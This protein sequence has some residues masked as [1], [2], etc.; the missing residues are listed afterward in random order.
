MFVALKAQCLFIVV[1]SC[2]VCVHSELIKGL[3]GLCWSHPSKCGKSRYLCVLLQAAG[4][5]GWPP[6]CQQRTWSAWAVWEVR[7]EKNHQGGCHAGCAPDFRMDHQTG[8]RGSVWPSVYTQLHSS[9]CVCTYTLSPDHGERAAR[10]L[11]LFYDSRY[12]TPTRLV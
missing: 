12:L 5:R 2:L 11:P 10:G 9:Q 8:A 4:S 7:G 6:R 1:S 3:G